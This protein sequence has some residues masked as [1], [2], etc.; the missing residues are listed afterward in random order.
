MLSDNR[1]YPLRKPH[2]FLLGFKWLYSLVLVGQISIVF[3]IVPSSWSHLF[4]G[5]TDH[6]HG[7]PE[8]AL[9]ALKQLFKTL[10]W[11]IH[12]S[13]G[14]SVHWSIGHWSIGP[15]VH[16]PIGPLAHWPI[17]PLVHWSIG[18]LSYWPIGTLINYLFICFG[19]YS[20]AGTF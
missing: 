4:Q 3:P 17:G 10:C 9:S 19:V 16:W 7:V 14:T 20:L 18:L 5:T 12:R 1:K 2:F 8:A 13:I 15:L 6:T 11:L